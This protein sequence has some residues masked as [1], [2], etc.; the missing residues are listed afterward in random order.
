MTTAL[1]VVDVQKDFCEGG[2]LAVSGGNDVAT[3]I[4]NFLPNS[5]H[6]EVFYTMD[7]HN[8]PP[9]DNGGHFGDP[10]D[11][12]DTW[13]VHCV[14]GTDGAKLHPALDTLL[15]DEWADNVFKKGQGQP[16]YSG[17]QGVNSHGDSLDDA[18][19][20]AGVTKIYVVGLAGDY[21]VRATAQD[22]YRNG[23][24]V[25]IYPDLVA[26]V[27][28]IIGTKETLGLLQYPEGW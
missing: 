15:P 2:S 28:G 23:Y 25:E 22:G 7:W 8:A 21:C 17:F 12:I 24:E 20:A 3:K 14:A 1:I 9:D 16:H 18:L 27:R 10:P 4:A 5:P 6:Q 26:S 19:K 11:F 13:P